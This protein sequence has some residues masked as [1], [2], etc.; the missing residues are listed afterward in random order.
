M[1]VL[2]GFIGGAYMA[3]SSNFDAQRCVNLY[4]EKSDSG[5]S[6]DAAMLVG[7]PGLK[8]W[9]TLAGSTVRGCI[10]FDGIYSFVVVG[11][12]VY[13]VDTSG[14]AELTGTIVNNVTPVSMA[15]NGTDI[16]MVTGPKGYVIDPVANTLVEYIDV[17]FSGADRVD[18]INGAFVFNQPNSGKFWAMDPYSTTLDPLYFATAEGSPDALVS[19][20]V[21][22]NEIWLFGSM[23]S[24]I[25]V[26][27]GDT[28]T[29]PYQRVEG[30]FI[31]QGC[32]AVHS[33]A[34][35]DMKVFWLS[36]NDKGQGMVFQSEGYSPKRVSTHAM[37]KALA[38]YET[39]ADAVAYTYQQEGHTFYVLNF[40]T[41]NATWAYDTTTG[42]WGERLW[43]QS[44]G[45][46][47]RHRGNCHMYFNRK[48]LVG[49]WQTGQIYE[50][51]L[52][53]Y[54]DNGNALVRLRSSPHVTMEMVRVVHSAIQF[55]METGTG[56]QSGQ[57]EDPIAMLRWSDD[58][59]HTWSNQRE[60]KI[61]K[62]GNYGTRV[63]Y[64]RL[65]SSRDRVYELSISDPIKVAII[66][67][68]IN[69]Q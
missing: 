13:R 68:I 66:G 58:G 11:Q 61:G 20:I 6:K 28:A 35:A 39:I 21:N 1:P 22:Q 27:N 15:S 33:V 26:Y 7:T 5:T 55:D 60:G 54:T 14:A 3:R 48:N 47:G 30:A 69:G 53:T 38:K 29:F 64:T 41:A 52:D 9:A 56:L 46:W 25:W 51:D 34:K 67:A 65:G 42:L 17:S 31:D 40:P 18:F 57:G 4:V 23:T 49:D 8:L 32:A 10:N 44:D 62:V 37:E 12:N 45:Q 59:G 24:E 43:R 2:Q 19:L 50:L 16:F 36:A 63:R